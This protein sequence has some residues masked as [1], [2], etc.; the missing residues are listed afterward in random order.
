MPP[1]ASTCRCE[2]RSGSQV[3]AEPASEPTLLANEAG[4]DRDDIQPGDRCC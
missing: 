1:A 3:L 2:L 4:D